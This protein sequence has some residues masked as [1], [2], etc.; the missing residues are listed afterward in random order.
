MNIPILW[1]KLW[2]HG[3]QNQDTQVCM[4]IPARYNSRGEAHEHPACTIF[5]GESSRRWLSRGLRTGEKEEEEEEEQEKEEKEE[6]EK[7][8]FV[9]GIPR[10]VSRIEGRPTA[11]RNLVTITRRGVEAG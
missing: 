4:R 9:K 2:D 7:S 6:K 8:W 10:Y 11:S 1:D 5:S 3:D